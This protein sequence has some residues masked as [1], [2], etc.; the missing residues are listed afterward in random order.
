MMAA[1]SRLSRIRFDELVARSELLRDGFQR[2][3]EHI[4]AVMS[5]P[6]DSTELAALPARPSGHS[7]QECLV[8]SGNWPTRRTQL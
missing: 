1:K 3:R 7:D 4:P 5:T 6:A 2:L 8:I